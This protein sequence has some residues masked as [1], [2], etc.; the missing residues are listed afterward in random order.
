[1]SFYVVSTVFLIPHASF[2][3]VF[4]DNTLSA[5][6]SDIL[7][8]WNRQ[9]LFHPNNKPHEEVSSRSILN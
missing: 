9:I 2:V 1:M 8:R 6:V 4:V 5:E 7:C 3:S